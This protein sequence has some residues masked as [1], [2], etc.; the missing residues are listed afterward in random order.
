MGAPAAAS[1]HT[2][3]GREIAGP[4]Q[5]AGQNI[6]VRV[7]VAADTTSGGLFLASSAVEKPTYG[8]A[9]EVGPGKL[10]GNGVAIP[11]TVEKGDTVLYG[12]YGGT[13]VVYDDVKH[14]FVT[15]DDVLATL[16]GG[17]FAADAVNPI[18]DRVLIRVD[19]AADKTASGIILSSGAA[20]KP[21]SGTIA[22]LGPGRFME[23]GATESHGFAVGDTVLYGKYSGTPIE[24]G[25]EDYILIRMADIYAKY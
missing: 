3:D 25:D 18:F 10:Y 15:Q 23:N 11:M 5:P 14:T 6:L 21:T 17:K 13:D 8:C 9:V 20:E 7:A 2:L 22:A 24:F 12:K 16:A 1:T 4:V 19:E